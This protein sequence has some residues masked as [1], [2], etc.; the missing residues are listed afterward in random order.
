M[1]KGDGM[2]NRFIRQRMYTQIAMNIILKFQ[3]EQKLGNFMSSWVT[4]LSERLTILTE[5]L[6]TFCYEIILYKHLNLAVTVQVF[7]LLI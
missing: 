6:V 5:Q 2:W 1:E 4:I 7:K 3:V